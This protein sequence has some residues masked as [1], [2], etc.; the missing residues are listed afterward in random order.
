MVSMQKS[1]WKTDHCGPRYLQKCFLTWH[2]KPNWNTKLFFLKYL[3]SGKL[4][5]QTNFFVETVCLL[6][7]I[8]MY[9]QSKKIMN[10]LSMNIKTPLKKPKIT[11]KSHVIIGMS[12]RHSSRSAFGRSTGNNI[13]GHYKRHYFLL[14]SFWHERAVFQS[15]GIRAADWQR[16]K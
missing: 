12:V 9:K 3:G 14:F 15:V 1:V 7:Y 8:K 5:F 6:E 4:V 2:A 11:G 13:S 10:I 16:C